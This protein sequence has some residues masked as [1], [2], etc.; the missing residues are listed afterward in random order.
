MKV[1]RISGFRFFMFH[2]SSIYRA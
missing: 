1:T 2:N